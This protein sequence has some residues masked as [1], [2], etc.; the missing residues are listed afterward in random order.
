MCGI[1]G[2]IHFQ[3]TRPEKELFLS[4]LKKLIQRGP[5]THGTYHDDNVS[6][7]H[8]RLSI[9]DTSEN[10]AQPF[11][12]EDS[13]YIFTFNGE[14]FNYKDLRKELEL[15]GEKFRTSSDTEVLVKLLKKEGASCLSRLNGFFAFAFYD[16]TERKIIIA[17]DRYGVKPLLYSMTDHSLVFASEMKAL[18]EL[19][20]DKALDE[21]SLFTY[22]Q[23]NYIPAP[24]T[25]FKNVKKL[26]AG[27]F[28]EVDLNTK[29]IGLHQYYDIAYKESHFGGSY[30]Q[31]SEKLKVLLENSVQQRLVS[32]VPLG[33]FLS[34]GVDSSI[35]TAIAARL[36]PGLKTFSIG[37]KDE[38]FFDE[39]RFAESV[40]RM[41]HTDHTVF[42]L[43]NDDLFEHLFDVLNYIDEPFAD[44]SALNVYILSK[45]T[46]KEVTVALS[47]DGADEL[48]A[49]YNKH[50]ALLK[51]QGAGITNLLV[52]SLSP[53]IDMIPKSRNSKLGNFSRQIHKYKDGITLTEPERYWR[54]AG[55]CSEKEVEKL[56]KTHGAEY[57]ERKREMLS[58]L[59]NN[60]NH[61]LYTDFKLV[62]Q[63]D[64]LVKVDMMSMAN[65]LEVRTPFLDYMVVDHVFS[66][67]ASY[68]VDR[69]HRKKILI[70]TFK[71]DLPR[72]LLS[73]PKHGFEVPLLKW[74][75]TDLRPLIFDDL[76]SEKFVR[77][78]GVF[79]YE[80]VKQMKLQLMSNNPN[81]VVARIWGLIV[82]QYWWKKYNS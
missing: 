68:K 24:G 45:E 25:I 2:K 5:D 34:G 20:I 62:L 80:T 81:D 29:R 48:F 78:Q 40:A 31:A 58:H 47:G 16:K 79:D 1:L 70:D 12:E 14:V 53:V 7:G 71:N 36:K 73:R 10:A 6:L 42:R 35:I 66:L 72:E 17:R 41:H 57:L 75:K 54:W 46:R 65:S 13:R 19:G 4:A 39:T 76:L 18:I 61:I 67:P 43:S 3:S 28:L 26:D 15:K 49:G 23:L 55:Y 50:T 30:D 9:I 82:F 11:A 77:E 33:C 59:D 63:N 56:Y 51:A 22:L 27:H 74:F 44:S 64:M 21:T 60:F 32:D 8:S 38:P 69:D 37:F 52:R